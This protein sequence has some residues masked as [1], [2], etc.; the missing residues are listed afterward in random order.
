MIHIKKVNLSEVDKL[1][2]QH[3][4]GCFT[5][6]LYH[7]HAI[8]QIQKDLDQIA[9]QISDGG[10]RSGF[11]TLQSTQVYS[12]SPWQLELFQKEHILVK[13]QDQHIESKQQ[14]D[15]WLLSIDDITHKEIIIAYVINNCCTNAEGVATTFFT[16]SGNVCKITKRLM[17]RIAKGIT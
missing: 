13:E 17:K 5:D 10:I 3:V 14:V 9:E 1:K 12:P 11:A 15:K 4:L 2:E 8:D 7:L 16:T 6:Y